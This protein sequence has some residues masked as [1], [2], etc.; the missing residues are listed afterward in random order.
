M[1][2]NDNSHIADQ[3][4]G[5]SGRV[6]RQ[7]LEPRTRGLRVRYLASIYYRIMPGRAVLSATPPFGVALYQSLSN[8]T[9]TSEQTRSKHGHKPVCM[10]SRERRIRSVILAGW[11]WVQD[12]DRA[13]SP[14]RYSSFTAALLPLSPT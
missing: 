5:Q 14:R 3:L 2:H 10:S 1:P 12:R 8:S 4:Y 9:V 6:R 11:R 7:G 13:I